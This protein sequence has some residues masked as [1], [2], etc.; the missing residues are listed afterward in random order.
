LAQ[1]DERPHV[2]R[3]SLASLKNIRK[4]YIGLHNDTSASQAAFLGAVDDDDQILEDPNSYCKCTHDEHSPSQPVADLQI[5][6]PAPEV[7]GIRPPTPDIP[8][9]TGSASHL[10][11][12]RPSE[13]SPPPSPYSRATTQAPF[14]SQL[15]HPSVSHV[16]LQATL[17]P[18]S[19]PSIV[20]T[21]TPQGA[22][23]APSV[24]G[25][26]NVGA[27]SA[28]SFTSASSSSLRP[29]AT[30]AAVSPEQHV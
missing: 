25:A 28:P 20:P 6:E 22:S 17:S 18:I 3:V 4:L 9:S 8:P 13:H 16:D 10:H 15:T 1:N 7:V 30:G 2:V 19:P 29:T 14:V 11:I 23:M 21:A 26:A 27:P 12:T 5:E 24:P